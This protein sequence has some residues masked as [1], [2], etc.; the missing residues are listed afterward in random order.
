[1]AAAKKKTSAEKI[2][3]VPPTD[4]YERA[5]HPVK[6]RDGASMRETIESVK[7]SGVLTLGTVRPRAEGGYEIIAGR[8]RKLACEAAGLEAIG[9][10][11]ALTPAEQISRLK[12]EEQAKGNLRFTR[13]TG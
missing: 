12:P 9:G 3:S 13:S 4:L 5:D 6:M 2:T 1:M 11:M 7:S 8:R 10:T